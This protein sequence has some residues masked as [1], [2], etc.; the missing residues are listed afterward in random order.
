MLR[1]AAAIKTQLRST[2]RAHEQA[3]DSA[4][5]IYGAS[6]IYSMIP[7]NG[8][9]T[10][11][12]SIALAN[13]AIAGP[14]DW[15]WIHANNQT[16]RPSL[17]E[18][19]TAAYS[20][21]VLRCPYARLASCYLE[22]FVQRKPDAWHYFAL[23][24]EEVAPADLTFRQFCRAVCGPKLLAANIHWRPQLSFL[25]YA[26]YDDYFCLED[27]AAVPARLAARIG[28]KVVDARPLARHDN[29]RFEPLPASETHADT[30]AWK[31]ETMMRGGQCPH[32]ASLYD[33]GLRARVDA[34]YKEDFAL[35]SRL[36]PGRG[37]F[38]QM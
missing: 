15:Q 13:G 29:Q 37:L 12:L 30:T 22:K 18:L 14:E 38:E 11:R 4:M 8:C 20:F 33:D 23:T 32:P 35:F 31:I 24:D 34:A 28:L 1:Y 2:N 16:F 36:F 27:F 17:A 19:A 6:A 7:K 3:T 21:A 25:V 10:L 5:S 26:D 9:T